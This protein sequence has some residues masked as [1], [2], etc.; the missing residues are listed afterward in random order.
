MIQKTFLHRKKPPMST[1]FSVLTV[2]IC[3]LCLLGCVFV[4]RNA[5][6]VTESQEAAKPSVERRLELLSESLKS[7]QDELEHLAQKVKMQRVRNATDHATRTNGGGS[8]R[9]GEPDPYS[10]PDEWRRMMED[11]LARRKHGV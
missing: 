7:T 10:Q 6:H 8:G 2:V 5:S 9:N 4:V 3:T 1:V 11:K